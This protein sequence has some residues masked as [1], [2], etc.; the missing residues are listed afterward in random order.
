VHDGTP[1][2]GSLLDGFVYVCPGILLW[3]GEACVAM[4]QVSPLAPWSPMALFNREFAMLACCP[5]NFRGF[6]R[7]L[8]EKLGIYAAVRASVAAHK[9]KLCGAGC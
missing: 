6:S 7:W 1:F 5:L 3:N 4:L 8:P 2:V 9:W